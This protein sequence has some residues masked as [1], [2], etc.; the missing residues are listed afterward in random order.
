MELALVLAGAAAVVA[1]LLVEQRFFARGR[2]P[3]N[4]EA[5]AWS[6]GWLGLAVAVAV[7]IGAA[8]G[9]AGA[10]TTVYVIERSLSLDNVFLFSL[11]LG[12]FA[13]PPQLRGRVILIGIVGALALRG[14]AI[15]AGLALV[16]AAE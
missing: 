3:R 7:A 15:V 13:V 1:G 6:L 9:P 4:R 12:Y 16:S 2:A 14:V 8:G 10:W 5:V 11:L